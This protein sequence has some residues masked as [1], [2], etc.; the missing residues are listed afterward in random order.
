MSGIDVVFNVFS[1]FMAVRSLQLTAVIWRTWS[2]LIAAPFTHY[3][4]GIADQASFFVAVPIAVFLHELSHALA[5]WGFGQQV[6]GFHYRVF[7]GYVEHLD[8]GVPGQ[9]WFIS[10]A[11]T[12]GS[13]LFGVGVWLLWRYNPSATLRYFALRT[14]RFQ[15]YFSLIY[16]PVFTLLGFEGDW[17][18]IYNF[19]ATPVL[20]GITA[21]LHAALLLFFWQSDRTGWFEMPAH[22][23]P[24]AQQQFERLA[25]QLRQQTAVSPHSLVTHL[26]YVKHLRQGGAVNR[27]LWHLRQ[28]VLYYP[29]SPELYAEMALAQ[30]TTKQHVP[31]TAVQ[32]IYKA[33][34]LGLSNPYLLVYAHQLL[35]LHNL[36][37][38]QPQE[39]LF[40]LEQAIQQ[41]TAHPTTL[42]YPHAA[43]LFHI[44]SQAHRRLQQFD[45][46]YQDA[47]QAL[48]LAQTTQDPKL[49][50]YYQQQLKVIETHAKRPLSPPSSHP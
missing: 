32:N 7:W 2:S 25:A 11:G 42:T 5:I 31:K 37:M 23:T 46:A 44:R 6:L 19:S 22:D 28:L 20:S 13:L 9:Q 26:Q 34:D 8:T 15:M 50:D 47:Q 41:Y 30:T 36:D 38:E 12:V 14:F 27:A 18:T 49:N 45:A 39:A 40:Q 17:R 4:Q 10:L 33:F 35:G 21:V 43:H 16:Y 48:K 1:L 29:K 24:E 3:K